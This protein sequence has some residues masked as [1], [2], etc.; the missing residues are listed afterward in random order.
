M[1]TRHICPKCDHRTILLVDT[2]PDR[3]GAQ[4][5]ESFAAATPDG[6]Y[7]IGGERFAG[8][9]KLSA[10][11][12]KGCGYTE[13]YCEDPRAIPVDGRLVR[14]VTAAPNSAYR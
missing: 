1:R 4:V 8:A 3:I 9:G 11:I 12:C 13:L 6:D 10:A 5:H 2:L 14:E 7:L